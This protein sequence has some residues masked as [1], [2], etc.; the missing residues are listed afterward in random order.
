MLQEADV[1]IHRA[2]NL[3]SSVKDEYG[4]SAESITFVSKKKTH[5]SADTIETV[6]GTSVKIHSDGSVEIVSAGDITIS[7]GTVNVNPT[8]IPTRK[9]VLTDA[10]QPVQ[11]G[12]TKKPIEL[13][14]WEGMSPIPTYITTDSEL[15]ISGGPLNG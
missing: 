2:Q 11:R 7:G 8:N 5:V 13:P 6:A 14:Q 4:V 15:D 3:L 12:Y 9:S 10:S 1:L